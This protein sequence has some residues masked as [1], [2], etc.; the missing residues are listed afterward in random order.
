MDYRWPSLSR[1][2]D[3][4]LTNFVMTRLHGTLEEEGLAV[5][6]QAACQTHGLHVLIVSGEED[7]IAPNS[8]SQALATFIGA[9]YQEMSGGHMPH[10]GSP[11]KFSSMVRSYVE[12]TGP[13]SPT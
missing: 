5:R 13:A 9:H 6:L 12:K 10:E 3:R 8:N 7:Q 4:G 11:G 1:D 2:W